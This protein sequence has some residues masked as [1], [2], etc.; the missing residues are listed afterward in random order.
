MPAVVWFWLPLGCWWCG[1][2]RIQSTLTR[3]LHLIWTVKIFFHSCSLHGGSLEVPPRHC[4][5]VCVRLWGSSLQAFVACLSTLSTCH[6]S[7]LSMLVGF[8]VL[9]VRNSR[10]TT[11]S[12][13]RKLA[14]LSNEEWDFMYILYLKLLNFV[15]KNSPKV[16]TWKIFDALSSH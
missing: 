13:L 9:V 1:T 10:I 2:A 6:F 16:H 7:W 11:Q 15:P 8:W 14:G 5:V 12:V 4:E 3:A